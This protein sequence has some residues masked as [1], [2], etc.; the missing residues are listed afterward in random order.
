MKGTI[1][2]LPPGGAWTFVLGLSPKKLSRFCE[3]LILVKFQLI[4]IDFYW[5]KI[6]LSVRR[7]WVWGTQESTYFE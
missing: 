1:I 5:Q 2:Y 7:I 6:E 3:A 4:L